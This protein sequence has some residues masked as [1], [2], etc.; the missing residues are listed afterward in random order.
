[1][2]LGKVAICLVV[3]CGYGVAGR[4]LSNHLQDVERAWTQRPLP[5]ADVIL[6][7]QLIPVQLMVRAELEH[8]ATKQQQFAT[9]L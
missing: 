8:A 3:M 5:I 7:L 9:H 2:K 4:G 1:M 6:C